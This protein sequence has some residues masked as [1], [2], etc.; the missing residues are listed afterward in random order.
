MSV[1]NTDPL[2]TFVWLLRMTADVAPAYLALLVLPV[3]A[4]QRCGIGGAGRALSSVLLA[5]AG[6]L[7]M[8]SMGA[9]LYGQGRSHS[10]LQIVQLAVGL[11]GVFLTILVTRPLS[12]RVPNWV[13]WLFYFGVA[14]ITL[15]AGAVGGMALVNDWI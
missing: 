12:P 8:L 10:Y 15:I 14:V 3:A 11:G 4:L 7:A 9:W 13:F 6:P 5:H 1:N 2:A